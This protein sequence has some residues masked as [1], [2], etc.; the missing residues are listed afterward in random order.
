MS[1]VSVKLKLEDPGRLWRKLQSQSVVSSKRGLEKLWSNV[2]SF[3]AAVV[4]GGSMV[5]LV[6]PGKRPLERHEFHVRETR[7]DWSSRG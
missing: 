4:N 7:Y 2:G 5:R 3:V 1:L 6:G